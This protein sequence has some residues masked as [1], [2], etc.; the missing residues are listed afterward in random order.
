MSSK[1]DTVYSLRLEEV[2]LGTSSF[3]LRSARFLDILERFRTVD[4]R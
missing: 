2:N 3:C 1:F 4:W